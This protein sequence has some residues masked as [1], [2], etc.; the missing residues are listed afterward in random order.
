[1][2][3]QLPTPGADVIQRL[4]SAVHAAQKAYTEENVD[5]N[6]IVMNFSSTLSP[7]ERC[8]LQQ[9]ERILQMFGDRIFPETPS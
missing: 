9:L 4:M 8:A 5:I 1:M 2:L 3:D 7:E 6:E